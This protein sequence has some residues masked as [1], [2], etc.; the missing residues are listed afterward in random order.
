MEQVNVKSINMKRNS[1]ISQCTESK[2]PKLD[3]KASLSE[4]LSFILQNTEQSFHETMS[5]F[6][7]DKYDVESVV[8]GHMKSKNWNDLHSK[9]L[10]RL[11]DYWEPLLI[12]CANKNMYFKSLQKEDQSLLIHNN[13]K[14]FKEY[15]LA[16]YITAETGIEQVSWIIGLDIKSSISKTFF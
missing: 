11:M 14:L 1:E 16:R 9:A 8:L 6:N 2:I 15:C 5:E 7:F 13:A 4:E 12:S 3:R 10:I